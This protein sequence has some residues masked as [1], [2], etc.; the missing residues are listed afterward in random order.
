MAAK[1]LNIRPLSNRVLVKR[2]EE[3]MQ[4][5]AGGIIVPDTAKEKPQRGKIVAV[6]PGRLTDEGERIKVE[7]KVGDEILFGKWSGSEITIDGDEYLFM[8]DDDILAVL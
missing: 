1:K 8:K 5:T 6:G 7:V 4:K 3:E 2:L